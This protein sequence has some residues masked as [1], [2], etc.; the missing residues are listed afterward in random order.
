[1]NRKVLIYNLGNLPTAPLDD[2]NELQEDFKISDPDKTAKLALVI[3]TRGFKY[4]FKA[5]RDLDGK[6]WIIDAH[7]RKKALLMLR[8]RGVE[9]PDIPYEPI[10]AATKKEAVEEIAAYNSEFATRN[11]DTLLFEKYNIGTDSL[12]QFSLNMD[13]GTEKH[14]FNLDTK[15][16]VTDNLAGLDLDRQYDETGQSMEAMTLSGDI[17]LLGDHRLMCGDSC[18]PAAVAR[19]MNNRKAD[20]CITDPPYNVDYEGGT[21]EHLSI[22]N[23]SMSDVAFDRFLFQAFKNVF[24]VLKAG[25]SVY[26]FHSDIQ[27]L[28]FRRNYEKAGFKLAQCCVWVK[29]SIVMGR[30]DYQ[31]QHEPVLYGWKPGAGHHW[32]ADRTQSTIWS[33]DR[34]VRNDIH[35]TMKPVALIAYPL[36]NSSKERDIVVDPFCGSGSTIMAC[37]QH[38]RVGYG[39]EL[40]PKFVDATVRRYIRSGGDKQVFLLR[41][42]ERIHYSDIDPA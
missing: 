24:T 39:M 19:L 23:D 8:A 36:L 1:M 29:N 18:D 5:W 15:R 32:Y 35:P 33:F 38:H 20:L 37:E 2:F 21:R 6:L 13:G 7:Q 31:W 10:Y 4:A 41:N 14:T 3:M 27:G 17:W 42:G 34:P 11:P 22:A 26:V 28:A 16:S 12:E 25:A 9:I 40:D 30:Q